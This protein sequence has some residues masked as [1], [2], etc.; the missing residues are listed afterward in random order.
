MRPLSSAPLAALD[1]G[2]NNYSETIA[3]TLTL[4]GR[5]FERAATAITESLGLSGV[6]AGDVIALLS[7]RLRLTGTV[8]PSADFRSTLTDGV[9]YQ[10]ALA[11]GWMLTLQEEVNLAASATGQRWV[12]AA[13]ADILHATGVVNVTYDARTILTS[14]LA[15]DSLLATGWKQEL[16]DTVEFQDALNAQ[17]NAVVNLV[18]SA[19]LTDAVA[20]S[21]RL[22]AICAD[23]VDLGDSLFPQSDVFE[24]LAE[25]VMFYSVIRLG[26]A[27]YVGWTLNS[28]A[29]TEYRHYPFNGMIE[30]DGRYYGTSD[31]GRYELVGPDDAGEAIEWSI[32]TGVM[33]FLTGR[34]KRV[35][36]CYFRFAGGGQVELKVIIEDDAGELQ[37]HIYEA[38]LRTGSSFHNDRIKIGRGLKA[39]YWQFEL[40]GTGKFELDDQGWRPLI[41]DRRLY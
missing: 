12:L 4:D 7:E 39:V 41:L 38:E 22:T 24:R 26:D 29:A 5:V 34:F 19:V 32:K 25:E 30:V 3:E 27:E 21:M 18:D 37:A 31:S 14:V 23:T 1:S 9:R 40:K 36:D 28:G 13:I 2:A 20:P 8:L 16:M 10:D 11:L 6:V 35:P 33:D 17:I 15:I